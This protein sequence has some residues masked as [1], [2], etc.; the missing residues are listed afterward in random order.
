MQKIKHV[1]KFET[2]NAR[3]LKF[4][5]WHIGLYNNCAKCPQKWRWSKYHQNN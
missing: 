5:I 3:G 4:E 2:D 1:G